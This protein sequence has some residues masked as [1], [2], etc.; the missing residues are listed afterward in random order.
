MITSLKSV[1]KARLEKYEK[2]GQDHHDT[3]EM[4]IRHKKELLDKFE[5]DDENHPN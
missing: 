4:L 1:F 2:L 3:M 5:T